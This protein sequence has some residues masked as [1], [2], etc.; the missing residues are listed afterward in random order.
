M[1]Q[2]FSSGFTCNL[3]V[4]VSSSHTTRSDESQRLIA[5]LRPSYNTRLITSSLYRL[6]VLKEA[7]SRWDLVLTTRLVL[8]GS[9]FIVGDCKPLNS[10]SGQRPDHLSSEYHHTLNQATQTA[11][12]THRPCLSRRPSLSISSCFVQSFTRSSVALS[13]HPECPRPLQH[14]TPASLS[15]WNHLLKGGALRTIYFVACW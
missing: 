1:S 15:L 14:S 9:Y 10:L 5:L 2:L 6:C 3:L 4:T 7:T 13:E 8:V 11:P 12:H